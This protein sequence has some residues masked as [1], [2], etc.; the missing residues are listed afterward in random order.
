M[1]S[2]RENH[3]RGCLPGSTE[4]AVRGGCRRCTDTRSKKQQS[5]VRTSSDG[6]QTSYI[7][8]MKK[9]TCIRIKVCI[10][11]AKDSIPVRE[12]LLT[13]TASPPWVVQVTH[14]RQTL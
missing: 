5:F 11:E 12:H 13:E 9:C 1:Q 10:Q 14:P 6:M 8:K 4:H 2:S 3:S 7:S